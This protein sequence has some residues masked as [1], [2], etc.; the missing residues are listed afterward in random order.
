MKP[1]VEP[2]VWDVSAGVPLS[3]GRMVSLFPVGLDTSRLS[4][5]VDGFL[6]DEE[7]VGCGAYHGGG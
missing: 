1:Q 7:T 6:T 4:I 5:V 2:L 3:F